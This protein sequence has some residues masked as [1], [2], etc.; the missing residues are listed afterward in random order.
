[1]DTHIYS[2]AL[3]WSLRASGQ[4]VFEGAQALKCDTCCVCIIRRLASHAYYQFK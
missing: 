3:V 1:V 4:L 2:G